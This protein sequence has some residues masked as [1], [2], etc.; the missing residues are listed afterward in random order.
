MS[1]SRSAVFRIVTVSL[2]SFVVAPSGA[3]PYRHPGIRPLRPASPSAPHH[4]VLSATIH[5][6]TLTHPAPLIQ[7]INRR[8]TSV[9]GGSSQGPVKGPVRGPVNCRYE[10][11][12]R[13]S[14]VRKDLIQA[15]GMKSKTGALKRTLSELMADGLI[16]YP[17]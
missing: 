13:P 11:R 12:P 16:E 4:R 6:H 3:S 7:F 15:L 5:T 2:S 8:P 14:H 10:G 9:A 1:G 17:L